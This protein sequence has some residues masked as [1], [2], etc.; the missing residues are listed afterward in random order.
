MSEQGYISPIIIGFDI[1]SDI[2]KATETEVKTCLERIGVDINKEE[3][4]K[5]LKYDRGQYRAGYQNG[6]LNGE[7]KTAKEILGLIHPKCEYCDKNWHK[8]CMCLEEQ[9][10][11]KIK[12]RFGIEGENEDE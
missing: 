1:V 11:N 12:A 5:A 6:Y 4:I 10:A 8:G 2:E 9:I 7:K 3:L